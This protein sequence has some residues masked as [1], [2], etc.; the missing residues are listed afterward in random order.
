M[1]R[2]LF[3]AKLAGIPLFTFAWPPLLGSRKPS[4]W[5][6]DHEPLS[7]NE[8]TWSADTSGFIRAGDKIKCVR[9]GET[10][11]VVH[12]DQTTVTVVRNV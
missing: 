2:R 11:R 12:A 7:G 5:L 8:V 9:S 4:T 6:T 3:L 1:N 10:M